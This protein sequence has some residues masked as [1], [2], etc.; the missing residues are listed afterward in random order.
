MFQFCFCV[1]LN[2][3]IET[4]KTG[5]IR[6]RTQQLFSLQVFL[7]PTLFQTPFIIYTRK[8]KFLPSSIYVSMFAG[9]NIIAD[10]L[11]LLYPEENLAKLIPSAVCSF[12]YLKIIAFFSKKN[13]NKKIKKFH[14][15]VCFIYCHE[16]RSL[17]EK[18]PFLWYSESAVCRHFLHWKWKRK[19]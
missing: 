7:F 6:R 10:T 4:S 15:K 2:H 11:L 16:N 13:K 8:F 18:T 19:H 12:R 17:K 9:I 5:S 14:E 3:N 1:S